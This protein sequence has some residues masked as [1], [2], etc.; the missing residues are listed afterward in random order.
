MPDLKF[1]HPRL[2]SIYGAF[3]AQ[4]SDLPHY[5]AIAN[6]L[7]AKSAEVFEGFLEVIMRLLMTFFALLVGTQAL[8]EIRVETRYSPL[9]NFIYQLDCVSGALGEYCSKKAYQSLWEKNAFLKGNEERALLEEWR[10]MAERYSHSFELVDSEPLKVSGRFRGVKLHKKMRIAA[11]KSQGINDYFDRLDMVVS[12]SDRAKIER[13]VRQLFPKFETWW[14]AQAKKF[15]GS[16]VEKADALVRSSAM[17][18]TIA[19]ASRFYGA[20]LP[21]DFLVTL[22]FFFRPS[23][24]DNTSSGEQVEQFSLLEFREE[25]TPND[26]IDV[27]V[28]ELS[29]FFFRSTGTEDLKTLEQNFLEK[30]GLAAVGAYNL[31]DE[32]AASAIGNGIINRMLRPEKDWIKFL[33]MERSFYNDDVIDKAGKAILPLVERAMANGIP[34]FSKEFVDDYVRRLEATFGDELLAPKCLS[35]SLTLVGDSAYGGKFSDRVR[36][37]LKVSSMTGSEGSLSEEKTLGSIDRSSRKTTMLIIH[38]DN[39]ARLKALD[40]LPKTDFTLLSDTYKRRGEAILAS[41]RDRSAVTY[42]V[43]AADYKKALEAVEKLASLRTGFE[44][45]LTL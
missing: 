6:E 26:R 35:K 19:N 30:R 44:G 40:L 17:H 21:S 32:A 33:A 1:E 31:L 43:V 8:A 9:S 24:G 37:A 3:D 15:G 18:S 13:V 5:L 10:L 20:S 29:H 25:E 4:R 36:A 42:V 7:R 12:A 34:Y 39:L 11:L 41:V 2:V 28:H 38:P 14:S 27:V 45:I 22:N 23:N 16:F